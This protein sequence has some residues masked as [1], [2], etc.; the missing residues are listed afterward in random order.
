MDKSNNK[1]FS[2]EVVLGLIIGTIIA[3][4]GLGAYFVYDKYTTLQAD[5]KQEQNIRKRLA[6]EKADL[7]SKNHELFL[8]NIKYKSQVE[9]MD[10][11]I[12]ICPADGTKKYHVYSCDKYDKNCGF[13]A[14]NT[15]QAEDLGYKPC[16]CVNTQVSTTDNKTEIVYVTNTGSMYHREGCSYLK[17]KN[18][19]T[20]E[21]AIAQGYEPCSRC[22]P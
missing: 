11:Y 13:Y 10:E 7:N 12:A 6:S 8:E 14:Y 19:I 1:I 4:V 21:K 15:A 20:K 16:S 9:F 3:A 18:P 5:Y 2:K 22:N 17:S